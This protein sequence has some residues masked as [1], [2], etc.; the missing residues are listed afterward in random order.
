NP[1][2]ATFPSRAA[3]S[4]T[5]AKLHTRKSADFEPN[6]TNASHGPRFVERPGCREPHLYPPV[7]DAKP[8]TAR[9]VI[10]SAQAEYGPCDPD[11]RDESSRGPRTEEPHEGCC[12]LKSNPGTAQALSGP[13]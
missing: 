8:T 6:S 2:T 10:F 7:P 11:A 4:A 9:C 13:H 12:L 3:S 1:S 5:A